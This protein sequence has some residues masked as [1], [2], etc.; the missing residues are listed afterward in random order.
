[1]CAFVH[2]CDK[3]M[4]TN[5]KRDAAYRTHLRVLTAFAYTI[6]CWLDLEKSNAECAS[7]HTQSVR[8]F[9]GLLDGHKA[10]TDRDVCEA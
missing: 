1:M 5:N 9:R 10:Y 7:S 8:I 3:S 6:Y 2:M 4:R